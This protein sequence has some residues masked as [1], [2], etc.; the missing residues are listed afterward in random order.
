MKEKIE[1]RSLPVSMTTNED[2]SLSVSGLVNGAGS[3]SEI[4]T[5]PKNG[6]KFRET[7]SPGVFTNAIRSADRIDFLSQ[8]DKSMILSTTDNNSLSLQETDKGLEMRADIAPTSWGND[9]YQLIKNGIIK[10]MSFGMRVLSDNW[11][12][13]ADGIPMRTINGVKLVE[14]S[15]VRN[16]AYKDSGI[17][18][19]DMDI[20]NDVDIPNTEEEKRDM[21]DKEEEKKNASETEKQEKDSKSEK[22]ETE[23]KKEEEGGSENKESTD[24]E[25]T[26]DDNTTSEDSKDKKESKIDDEKRSA[27]EDTFSKEEI[28]SMMDALKSDI[29]NQI[30]S[31]VAEIRSAENEKES[32]E[33]EKRSRQSSLRAY[34]ND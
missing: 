12:T 27:I 24:K 25:D 7:I 2:D 23:S 20:I 4:L 31:V 28:R 11:S 8:H 6:R 9:T 3:V 5:N 26:T 18:A 16:P 22:T 1:I 33:L 19:R 13:S 30:T 14:V 29:Q 21:A 10:G 15:A 17:E 32:K 34:Y